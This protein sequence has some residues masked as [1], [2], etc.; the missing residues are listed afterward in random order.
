M[1]VAELPSSLTDSSDD[2]CCEEP[3]SLPDHLP[4]MIDGCREKKKN[5]H[6]CCGNRRIVMI[7]LET[8]I[9]LL[10]R[11]L[12]ENLLKSEAHDGAKER[13]DVIKNNNNKR[14]CVVDRNE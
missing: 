3:R 2:E 4:D 14:V 8:G 1:D 5:E 10:L 6:H 7:Q 9:R 13:T 12:A 11:H